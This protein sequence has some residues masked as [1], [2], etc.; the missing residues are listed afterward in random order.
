MYQGNKKICKDFMSSTKS[1][2]GNMFI[3]SYYSVGL[4]WVDIDET[5]STSHKNKVQVSTNK[6][7]HCQMFYQNRDSTYT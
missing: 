7:L 5:C 3:Y 4:K 1:Y 2:I 6:S